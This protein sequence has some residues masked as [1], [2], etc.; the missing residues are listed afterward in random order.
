M[1][2]A[3]VFLGI[4]LLINIIFRL[5]S[6]LSVN[7]S[8]WYAVNV[9]PLIVGV[10]AR[11]SGIF[12]FA[13]VEILLYLLILAA[14]AGIVFLIIKLIKS[15]GGRLKILLRS[16]VALSCAAST[17]L[18]MF[19]FG[20][21]INYQRKPFSQ[22]SGLEPEM[23]SR[24]DLLG[25]ID[26]IIGELELLVPQINTCEDG[27]FVLDKSRFNAAARSSMRQL[28]ERYSA[29]DTYYPNPK[30]VLLS[31]LIL[32]P[33]LISGIFSPFTTEALY[34]A[35]MPD[36]YKPFTATHELSHLSGF[37]REDEAN[38][39]AFLACRE[40]GDVDFRYSGYVRA[41]LYLLGA[42]DGEDYHELYMTIPE[43]VRRQ[44]SIE[45]EYWRSFLST[46][47]GA[48]IAAVSNAV[49]D[50]Y[51]KTQGQEDGVKSYGRV[52]DL[53][54]ADYIMR[55]KKA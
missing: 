47:S 11:V 3:L 48:A 44:Y 39:I 13:A 20:C 6:R 55:N 24:E 15:R 19:L 21:E 46:P 26:E 35:D 32:S 10:G 50:T 29:L 33:A 17:L 27:A 1:K 12:P 38:F 36:S 14:V 31:R 42:Y 43:Q 40:S 25:V 18:L 16:F 9:Y 28:G 54:I 49:N 51:L 53:L 7:F 22:H 30:P 45:N 23:Y 34:N 5:I 37:M 2:K 4:T 52:T 41:L 8:E